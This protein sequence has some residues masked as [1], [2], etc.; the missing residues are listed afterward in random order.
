MWSMYGLS[1]G[2]DLS[3]AEQ[4]QASLPKKPARQYKPCFPWGYQLA[5]EGRGPL[6]PAFEVFCKKL[7]M[8]L[9]FI[10]P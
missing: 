3:W 8:E 6:V 9:S 7:Q 2:A 1:V 5:M 4:H 10:S